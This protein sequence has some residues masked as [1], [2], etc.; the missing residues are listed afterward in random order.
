M[1]KVER[2]VVSASVLTATLCVG[3]LAWFSL[4]PTTKPGESS[5]HL[6]S[7]YSAKPL[8]FKLVKEIDGVVAEKKARVADDVL[9]KSAGS[10][11]EDF[12]ALRTTVNTLA[13]EARDLTSIT[14]FRQ[15]SLNGAIY[16]SEYRDF[17]TNEVELEKG[18]RLE[19][20]EQAVVQLESAIPVEIA[21]IEAAELA[22]AQAQPQEQAGYYYDG[23]GSDESL[24]SRVSRIFS[25]LP[26]YLSYSIEGCPAGALACYTYTT[27]YLKVSTSIAGYGDCTIRNALAH[28]YRHY[29]QDISGWFEFDSNGQLTNRDWL[30]SDTYAFGNQYGC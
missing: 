6:V 1:L 24:D 23:G 2:I 27:H 16:T 11:N 29:I 17:L 8:T 5:V 13:K 22:E 14:Y 9:G 15:L 10:T 7:S 19:K 18:S 4:E 28:E 26:F 25:T 21:A 20:L 3:L 12:L 30:E